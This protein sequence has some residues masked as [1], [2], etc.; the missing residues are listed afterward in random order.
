[1][2][3]EIRERVRE[4]CDTAS[5][6]ELIKII[7]HKSDVTLATSSVWP[8]VKQ[9]NIQLSGCLFGTQD[10]RPKKGHFFT[11]TPV[12]ADVSWGNSHKWPHL[13]WH[14]HPRATVPVYTPPHPHPWW[15]TQ[16]TN[17]H[18]AERFFFSCLCPPQPA[19]SSD[20][21]PQ[22]PLLL[23]LWASHSLFLFL[24][25]SLLLFFLCRCFSAS[26][27]SLFFSSTF[28]SFFS[29]QLLSPPLVSMLH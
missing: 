7:R 4:R 25:L 15:I 8:T 5:F 21:K 12:I 17:T 26:S 11:P 22:F 3:G 6:I 29:H 10:N 16:H 28:I 1:M 24:S 9:V 2:S 27:F 14:I 18:T 20:R 13:R 23:L 19:A